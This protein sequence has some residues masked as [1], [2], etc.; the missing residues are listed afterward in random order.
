MAV[1]SPTCCTVLAGEASRHAHAM[2]Q[3]SVPAPGGDGTVVLTFSHSIAVL[4]AA[5]AQLFDVIAET[6]RFRP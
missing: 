6:M 5:F 3:R 4:A 1:A 2:M